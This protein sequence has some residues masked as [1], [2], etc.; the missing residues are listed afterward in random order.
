MHNIPLTFADVIGAL[1]IGAVFGVL[2]ALFV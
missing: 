1:A 2:L